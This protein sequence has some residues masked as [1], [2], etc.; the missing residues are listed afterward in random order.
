MLFI[1]EEKVYIEYESLFS[2]KLLLEDF[3]VR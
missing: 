3:G 2:W 1:Y